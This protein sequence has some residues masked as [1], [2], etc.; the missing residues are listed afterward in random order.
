MKKA[1]IIG[2]TSGIGRQLALLLAD[3]GFVVGATGRRVQN[4]EELRLERPANILVSPFDITSTL[5][6]S[7][8]LHELAVKLGGLDLLVICS[9]VGEENHALDFSIEKKT[10]DV[11]V[12]GFTEAADWGFAFFQKQ[13][14]GHLVAIT[15]IAGLR[16]SRHAPAY[17]ASKAYQ[18]SYMEGLRQKAK[19]LKYPLY[20][21]DIRPGFVDTDMAKGEGMFW[22]ASVEKAAGQIIGAIQNRK[23]VAYITKRWGIMAALLKILP[24]RIYQHV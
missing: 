5:E 21:T 22:V 11:N 7:E 16:G 15:S 6:V 8:R 17:Y 1:I 13:Q 23:Q 3:H 18:I 9:G 14:S 24:R 4:L 19:K 20:I 10:I 2:A 12:T